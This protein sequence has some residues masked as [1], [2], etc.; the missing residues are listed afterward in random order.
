MSGLNRKADIFHSG[1]DVPDTNRDLLS[2][3]TKGWDSGV[4]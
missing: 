1:H 3:E 4:L 2:R